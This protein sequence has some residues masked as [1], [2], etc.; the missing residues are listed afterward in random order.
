MEGSSRWPDLLSP[1]RTSDAKLSKVG[2]VEG[3]DISVLGASKTGM[4]IPVVGSKP[5]SKRA[6]EQARRGPSRAALQHV[7]AATEKGRGIARVERERLKAREGIENRRGPLP[8]IAD[9]LGNF[10][11]ALA[12]RR[13]GHGDRIPSL[14]VEIA[15]GAPRK[16]IAPGILPLLS[17]RCPIGCAVKLGLRRKGFARPVCVRPSFVMRHKDRPVQRQRYVAKHRAKAPLAI[18]TAPIVWGRRA[19]VDEFQIL[20]VGHF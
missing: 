10:K 9:K 18:P 11:S 7:M 3:T 5:V 1:A 17:R 14:K 4:E 15:A 20:P 16:V 19:R 2:E 13:A 8:P 12:C 6:A